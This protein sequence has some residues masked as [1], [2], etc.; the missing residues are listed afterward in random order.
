MRAR[1]MIVTRGG[2][3]ALCK[4]GDDSVNVPALTSTIKDR[5]GA[6]DAVFALTSLLAHAGAPPSI[7]GLVGNAAGAQAVGTVGNR[8]T[9][10]RVALVKHLQHLLK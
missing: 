4:A 3:G 10:D 5:V 6:G 2:A 8:T 9:L 7:L 1:S